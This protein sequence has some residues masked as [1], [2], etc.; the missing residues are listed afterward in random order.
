MTRPGAEQ[1]GSGDEGAQEA[2]D[3]QTRRAAGDHREGD[4]FGEHG[5]PL[6]VDIASGAEEFFSRMARALGI[7]HGAEEGQHSGGFA[8][9]DRSLQAMVSE[10]RATNQVLRQAAEEMRAA[11]GMMADLHPQGGR[12][13]RRSRRDPLA[14][15]EGVEVHNLD[16]GETERAPDPRRTESERAPDPRRT[17]SDRDRAQGRAARRSTQGV[18]DS[19]QQRANREQERRD[20][21]QERLDE[22]NAEHGRAHTEFGSGVHR[23]YRSPHEHS[24]GELRRRVG[25]EAHHRWGMG[26][27]D[28]PSWV[29]QHDEHGNV[30]HYEQRHKG[31]TVRDPEGNP[32]R[33]MAGTP[34]YAEAEADHQ[35][36]SLISH[37]AEH[38]A[39]YGVKGAL[40]AVPGVGEVLMAGEATNW[41]IGEIGRQRAK[42]APYQAIYGGSNFGAAAGIGGLSQAFAG[43]AS[44]ARSGL[45]NRAAELGFVTS[46]HFG[47]GMT[48]DQAREAFQGVSSLGY[49]GNNRKNTLD[50]V[51]DSYK[52]LGISVQESMQRVSESAKYTNYAM[53]GLG[54]GLKSVTE[55]A[56]KT[57]QSAVE[58]RKQF[59]TAYASAMQSGFGASSAEIATAQTNAFGGSNRLLAGMN[60][61][62]QA[63]SHNLGMKFYMA[64]TQG[65]TPGQLEAQSDQGNPAPLLAAQNKGMTQ[66]MGAMISPNLKK[67][68]DQYVKSE[69]GKGY[70]EQH[71][72]ALQN[73]ADQAMSQ[74]F[75]PSIARQYL[76][77]MGVQTEGKN[78]TQVTA[79]FLQQSY[80]KKPQDELAKVEKAHKIKPL[81][82]K[83][84][85]DLKHE[86]FGGRLAD[87][88]VKG[89]DRVGSTT[90]E[91]AY[92][93]KVAK[94]THE[95]DLTRMFGIHTGGKEYA[96]AKT[97]T[98]EYE[99]IQRKTGKDDPATWAAIK[100]FGTHPEEG[101]RVKTKDKGWRVVPLTEAIT[102]YRDQIDTGQAEIVGGANDGKKIGAVTGVRDSGFHED[103]KKSSAKTQSGK[104]L[105]TA[106]E[107]E[108]KHG[109][110][111][112]K[113]D[114]KDKGKGGTIHVDLTPQVKQLFNFSSSDPGVSMSNSQ[115]TVPTPAG[116]PNQ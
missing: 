74:G 64:G 50:F 31:Q 68:L 6:R 20:R 86:S 95:D 62:Q 49:L 69:G 8:A 90:D 67:N 109:G 79:E 75:E 61:A 92:L 39:L 65:K 89:V 93:K 107:W 46:Q 41:G 47:L 42:N 55:S 58:L 51:S 45:G 54:E 111:R 101:V 87:T 40:R 57:G 105:A 88:L 48:G 84:E 56:Q 12:H 33:A 63:W 73:L 81:S 44:T 96:Q 7:S 29:P 94:D 34:E 22:R 113:D 103:P 70:I 71:Q 82:K 77:S 18:R 99:K 108:K 72:G 110:E 2:R 21:V 85:H 97:A 16:T 53:S 23:G 1:G 80:L 76:Q 4:L 14:P 116:G 100:S 98:K 11:T 19:E 78:D 115:G 5:R 112:K 26:D 27:R 24:V 10:H 66:L 59:D 52:N 60:P 114:D 38:G 32:V 25:E 104:G 15:D 9:M 28:T 37:V 3:E 35:G 36:R 102:T 13:A 106:D 17:E 43:S 30:S 83:E 91:R